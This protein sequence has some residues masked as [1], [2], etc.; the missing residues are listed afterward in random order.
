MRQ[1]TQKSMRG[2]S[3]PSHS[4]HC[5]WKS[6]R[7]LRASMA[8]RQLGEGGSRIKPSGTTAIDPFLTHCHFR[9][10]TGTD[11]SVVK[12][13]KKQKEMPKAAIRGCSKKATSRS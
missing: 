2:A 4:Y 5:H 6:R 8:A 11:C 7:Y 13:R 1:S 9:V 12:A 3:A 10:Q